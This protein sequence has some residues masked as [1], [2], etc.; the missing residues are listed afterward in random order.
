MK[1]KI[2]CKPYVCFHFVN[3]FLLHQ[4]Q[5]K[6]TTL[7]IFQ[8]KTSAFNCQKWKSLQIVHTLPKNF[9]SIQCVLHVGLMTSGQI[10]ETR[11]KKK[12]LQQSCIIV[13]LLW[14][15]DLRP[16]AWMCVCMCAWLYFLWQCCQTFT[17]GCCR[18]APILFPKPPA[19]KKKK[20][21]VLITRSTSLLIRHTPLK[22][23]LLITSFRF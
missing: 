1:V 5:K 18:G 21:A 13:S 19:W 12:Q 8:N 9:H 4:L 7:K 22:W 23:H 2:L 15:C 10:C 20:A 14:H 17:G 6:K 3:S 16:L 11:K